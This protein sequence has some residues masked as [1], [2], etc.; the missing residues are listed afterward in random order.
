MLFLK[1]N[2][3]LS[4]ELGATLW[5]VDS[6]LATKKVAPATVEIVPIAIN[7]RRYR[8]CTN[9]FKHFLD[10][11]YRGNYD[12]FMENNRRYVFGFLA[13]LVLFFVYR[14]VTNPLVVTV[15]GTGK[16][17]VPASVANLSV[18]IL[19]TADTVEKVESA[20]RVKIASLRL[21]MVTGG[22]NEKSLSQTEMQIT[23]LSAVVS[24]TK[25]Y[26]AQV[27]ISGQT[28]D[29]ATLSSLV[30]R[31]YSAGAAIVSQPVIQV[32][33]QQ[34][35][36]NQALKQAL[37]D[38]SSNVKQISSGKRK[39]LRKM[40]ALNQATT[41]TTSINTRTVDNNGTNTPSVEVVKVVSAVYQLW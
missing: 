12:G 15:T 10:Y 20:A 26:S 24:G 37:A 28:S 2:G 21:A 3:V 27:Q 31:L 8:V 38:A 16:V 34:D 9:S 4:G 17:V 25:G 6:L 23:P 40:V 29:L 39:L 11:I 32:E 13:I 36:E 33:N 35:L 18:T 14:Y 41:G 22:M 7:A 1:A 30:V 5:S 19:E